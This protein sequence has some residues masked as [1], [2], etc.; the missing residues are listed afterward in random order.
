MAD[1][2]ALHQARQG[3]RLLAEQVRGSPTT[4][5]GEKHPDAIIIA[6]AVNL[7]DAE[8]IYE[9]GANYVFM[10]RIDAAE[11]LAR[12]IGMALNGT[13]ADFRTAREAKA[14]RASSR[15]EVLG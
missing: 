15:L 14:G 11:G 12:A 9:S 5:R 3:V 6:N 4:C 10:T 2:R 13:I 8:A 7:A 1:W